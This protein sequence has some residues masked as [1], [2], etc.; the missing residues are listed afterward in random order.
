[1][2]ITK[3]APNTIHLSGH[4]ENVN[5]VAAGGTITPGYLV[6]RY[7]SSGTP[8][9][10]AH[11]TAGGKAAKAVALNPSMLNKGVDDTYTTGDLV[12]V[13]IFSPGAVAWM[14]LASGENVVS[15]DFLESKG[16]GTVRKFTSG[17][18][19]LFQVV[20]N[21]NNTAGPA[22]ARVKAEAL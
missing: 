17:T 22:T 1:M 19:A 7:N 12:E 8:L 2:A 16:D 4:I 20:E 6:E 14:L 10:R 5:D 9:F 21:V 3:R 11:S 15:G 13:G 18:V